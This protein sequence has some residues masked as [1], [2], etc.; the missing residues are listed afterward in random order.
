M[1][2]PGKLRALLATA[3]VANL[4]S[5]V[6]NVWLGCWVG[7]GLRSML[8]HEDDMPVFPWLGSIVFIVAGSL[9]YISGNF[10]N[11]WHDRGWDAARRPERAL[12][13]G[14]FRPSTYLAAGIGTGLAACVAAAWMN[15]VLL[16]LSA[17]IWLFVW[18]YTISHK[19]S[20]ECVAFIAA[21]RALLVVLGCMGVMDPP[22]NAGDLIAAFL[23]GAIVSVPLFLYIVALSLAARSESTGT[24]RPGFRIAA[25]ALLVL[26]PLLFLGVMLRVS[27]RPAAALPAVLPY[28]GW[29]FWHRFRSKASVKRYISALLAGIPLV[30][31][32]F[33]LLILLNV[34]G[35]GVPI[36]VSDLLILCMPIPAFV[37]GLLLQR[38]AP[39]T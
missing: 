4:P 2:P 24:P 32:M 15:P 12:P 37:L 28:I 3:R 22:W 31:L 20:A 38:L 23:P 34:P 29:V 27:D 14:M 36:A 16:P 11:D 33:S 35:S 39:A 9:L 18:I 13:R 6:S 7:H 19:K 10:L 26:V 21:C 30:D 25:D 17:A 1:N 8:A 5:V